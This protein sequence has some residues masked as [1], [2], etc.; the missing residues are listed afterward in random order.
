MQR[1]EASLA[2]GIRLSLR[3]G[4]GAVGDILSY[5]P[6]R[7]PYG[8][9]PLRGVLYLETLGRDP[10]P[11]RR[12]LDKIGSIFQQEKRAGGLHL[13]ISPHTPYTLSDTTLEAVFDYARRHRVPMSMHLAESPE[14][15]RFLEAS[16]GDLAEVLYPFVGWGDDVP[17]VITSYSIHYT[18]LYDFRLSS[19]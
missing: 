14:E 4:T 16:R 13:G 3:A 10:E 8:S 12:L 1:Y 19:L 18:K 7:T 5:F 11:C 6:A 17:P 2:E 9:S 15:V